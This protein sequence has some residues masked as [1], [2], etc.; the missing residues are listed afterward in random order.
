VKLIGRDLCIGLPLLSVEEATELVRRRIDHE[1]TTNLADLK[2]LVGKLNCLPL[3]ISQAVAYIIENG[4]A[5]N[6][7]LDMLRG[8]DNEIR[9]L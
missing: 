8:P 5:V 6:E 9:E 3:A 7:Y 1:S 4:I 2:D